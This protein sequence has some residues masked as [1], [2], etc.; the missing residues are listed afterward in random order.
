MAEPPVAS[1]CFPF[2]TVFSPRRQPVFCIF[3]IF[4]AFVPPLPR[5]ALLVGHFVNDIGITKKLAKAWPSGLYSKG[6]ALPPKNR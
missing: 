3:F 6:I 2:S 5:I 4:F 1:Q